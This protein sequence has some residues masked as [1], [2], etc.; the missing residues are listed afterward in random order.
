MRM[1]FCSYNIHYGVGSDG[2]YDLARIADIV[3]KADIVC[4]QEVTSGWKQNG[5]VDQ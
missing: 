1:L 2:K 4:L 3:A 5:F